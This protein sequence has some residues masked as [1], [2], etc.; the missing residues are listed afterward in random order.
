[1]MTAHCTRREFFRLTMGTAIAATGASV[2]GEAWAQP[3]AKVVLI[4][5]ADV[6]GEQAKINGAIVQTM[7]DEAVQTLVGAGNPA[8]AWRALIRPTDVVGIKSNAWERLPTPVEVEAAIR[9]RVVDAGVQESRLDVADRGVLQNPIFRNATALVNV[10]P[11]RTHHWA[12]VGTCLK[13]YIQFVPD[14]PAYHPDGC[15]ALGQIWTLPAVKGKT[16]LNILSVL[17]PQFYGRGANF[18]DRRYV[19]PYQGLIVGTDPVAVDTVGAHLLQ[20][21]R[22]AFFGEDRALDVTPHH[23]QLADTKYGLGVSD[24]ARIEVVKLGWMD[25][26]LI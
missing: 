6:V 26:V 3:T 14:R 19:W 9:R 2:F 24:L 1:M 5:H 13:N 7:L 25:G 17:M 23:I 12:G 18:F 16:R 10:R 11:L 15:A 8:D 20:A 21:K 4:R 22:V